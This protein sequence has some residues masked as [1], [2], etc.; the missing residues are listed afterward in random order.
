MQNGKPRFKFAGHAKGFTGH[1]HK[2]DETDGL[3]YPVD[4]KKD[5]VLAETGELCEEQLDQPFH[6]DVQVPSSRRL[7]T[8]NQLKTSAEGRDFGDRFETEVSVSI[9]G[10]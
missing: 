5:S 6:L 4:I 9:L 10:L 7:V 2:V 8:I 1:F 3:N